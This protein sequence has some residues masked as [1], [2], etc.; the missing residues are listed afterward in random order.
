MKAEGGVNRYHCHIG[1]SYLEDDLLSK[2]VK[3]AESAIWVAVRM[4][5]ERR[6]LLITKAEE[7][8]ERRLPKIGENY[9]RKAEDLKNHIEQIKAVLV[10][11][12]TSPRV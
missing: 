11:I 4:L 12:E 9:Y 6:H 10:A 8:K 2:Q 5:E 1:H 7:L 3:A